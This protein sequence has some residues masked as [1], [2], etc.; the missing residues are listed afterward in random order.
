MSQMTNGKASWMHTAISTLLLVA[1]SSAG[2]QDEP[3]GT[4]TPITQPRETTL[5]NTAGNPANPHALMLGS[6][7]TGEIEN[8]CMNGVCSYNLELNTPSC[9][10]LPNFTGERCQHI[11]LD[12]HSKESPEKLIAIGVGVALLLICLAGVLI[13]C[14]KKRCN[15]KKQPYHICHS[16]LAA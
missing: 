13:C 12:S 11:L 2:A 8:F 3:R 16:E 1:I 14:A 5:P 6:P 9:R 15:N 4:L 7:C 10:C